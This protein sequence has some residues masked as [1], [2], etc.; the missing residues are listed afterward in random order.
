MQFFARLVLLASLTAAAASQDGFHLYF[1]HG[2]NVTIAQP[3]LPAPDQG[4]TVACWF[5][6]AKRLRTSV[7]LLAIT[8]EHKKD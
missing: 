7:S 8:P 3:K 2:G 6:G 1:G 4:L 5:R